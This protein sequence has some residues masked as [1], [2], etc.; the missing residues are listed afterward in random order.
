MVQQGGKSK[1]EQCSGEV[2]DSAGQQ[3]MRDQDQ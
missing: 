2:V 1:R 3:N